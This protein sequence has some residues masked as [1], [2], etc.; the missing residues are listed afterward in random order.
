MDYYTAQA[1]TITIVAAFLIF[2][3]C[4]AAYMAQR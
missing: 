1:L 2:A 4:I 3:V